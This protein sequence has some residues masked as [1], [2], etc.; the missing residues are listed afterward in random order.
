MKR[1]ILKFN[2]ELTIK[3]MPVILQNIIIRYLKNIT[4]QMLFYAKKPHLIDL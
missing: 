2:K 1:K 3:D 4:K